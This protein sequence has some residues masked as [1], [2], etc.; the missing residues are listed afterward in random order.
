MTLMMPKI[1]LGEGRGEGWVS[2]V[3]EQT[4]PEHADAHHSLLAEHGEVA[5]QQQVPVRGSPGL[6]GETLTQRSICNLSD[7]IKCKALQ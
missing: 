5:A 7:G 2:L 3:H 6:A 4:R 1:F